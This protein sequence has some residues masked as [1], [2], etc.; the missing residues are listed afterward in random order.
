[1]A[2]DRSWHSDEAQG[3]F[4]NCIPSPIPGVSIC[5]VGWTVQINKKHYGDGQQESW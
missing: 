3:S 4:D 2:S 5:V 1:M